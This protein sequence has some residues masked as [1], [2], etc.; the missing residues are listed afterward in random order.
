LNRFTIPLADRL[1]AHLSWEAG[2]VFLTAEGKSEAL[3]L[4]LEAVEKLCRDQGIV[5]LQGA[6]PGIYSLEKE[7][8]LDQVWL[9][10]GYCPEQRST[11]LVDL[12]A[13]EQTLWRNLKSSARKSI[14]RTVEQG[15]TVRR[16][17]EP[18]E[19]SEYHDFLCR[20]REALG[21]ATFS[22]RNL[23][24]M[25]RVLFPAGMLEIFYIRYRGALAGGLGI[26]HH[27]G[28]I[29]EWGSLQAPE[30]KELK[31]YCSDLLKWE[32][33]RWGHSKGCRLYDLA[34]VVTD[35]SHS[36]DKERGIYQFKAKWGGKQQRFPAYSKCFKPFRHALL[37]EGAKVFRKLRER[38]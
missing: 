28:V 14:R 2:P 3:T 18:G 6:W 31:L 27:A 8:Q 26:W 9:S 36:G 35:P 4:L 20:C 7:N 38:F 30:A 5:A 29:Y 24:E 19:L 16:I 22:L 33:I 12:R 25:W 37:K 17:I 23:T 21:L 13:D 1:S 15:L 10:A 32:V 11:F 34:G